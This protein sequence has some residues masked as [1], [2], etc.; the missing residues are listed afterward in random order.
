[1]EPHSSANVSRFRRSDLVQIHARHAHLSGLPSAT[2]H[3]VVLGMPNEGP[4]ANHSFAPT[5]RK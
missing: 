3:L 4:L 5:V 2:L 1:M